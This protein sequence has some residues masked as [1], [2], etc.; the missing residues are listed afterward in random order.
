MNHIVNFT[1]SFIIVYLFYLITVIIQK[2]RYGEF[3]KGSQVMYF[4]NKYKLNLD[5]INIKKL[6]NILSLTNSFI[7]AITFTLVLLFDNYIIQLLVGFVIIIIIT[8][9]CYSFIGLYL[10]KEE[11]K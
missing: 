1:V 5:N 9:I 11:N 3:K 2:K 4:V 6:I 8:L 7:I 10:K